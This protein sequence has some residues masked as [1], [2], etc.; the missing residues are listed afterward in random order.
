MADYNFKTDFVIG[1]FGEYCWLRILETKGGI[2]MKMCDNNEYDLMVFTNGKEVKHEVKTDVYCYPNYEVFHPIEKKMVQ[3]EGKDTGNIFI[4]N[5][6]YGKKSGVNVCK[7]D[8]FVYY[9]PYLGQF[10]LIK[11]AD[12]K[13]LV[14]V[15]NFEYKKYS[16]DAGSNTEGWVIPREQYRDNFKVINVK[17]VPC[18]DV[19]VK[20]VMK[21]WLNG[22]GGTWLQK[23]D[24]VWFEKFAKPYL[25]TR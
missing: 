10:W 8:W 21:G 12:L 11:V 24:R 20:K 2:F 14:K 18:H 3:V 6:S 23:Y 13:K 15:E 7:A 22:V 9:Y 16:G 4:E 1:K 25:K 17:Q 19:E 5:N